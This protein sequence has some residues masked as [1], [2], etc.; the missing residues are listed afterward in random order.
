M[1]T[2]TNFFR[3]VNKAFDNLFGSD[4]FFFKTGNAAYIS[5]CGY[6][7]YRLPDINVPEHGNG[8]GRGP[9]ESPTLAK[10]FDQAVANSGLLSVN[11]TPGKLKH[12]AAGRKNVI[13]FTLPGNA[14]PAYIAAELLRPFNVS[15]ARIT[16]ANGEKPHLRPA[17]IEIPDDI[18]VYQV[19]GI[20]L[21]IRVTDCRDFIPETGGSC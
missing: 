4:Y 16:F 6:D 5:K 20:V 3:K 9:R 8:T 19:V 18:G 13:R 1:Y 14:E 12:A 17:V 15:S 21:P 11:R 2:T 7:A 10:L